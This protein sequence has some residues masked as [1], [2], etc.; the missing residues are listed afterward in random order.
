MEAKVSVS[1]SLEMCSSKVDLIYIKLDEEYIRL[2][3]P[4]IMANTVF[5]KAQKPT[6]EK[7]LFLSAIQTEFPKRSGER[8]K[9]NLIFASGEQ[10]QLQIEQACL[11]DR[12]KTTHKH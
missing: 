1:L 8:K 6:H 5:V 4:F 10:I 11:V 12:P 2:S 3:V 9:E 7:H